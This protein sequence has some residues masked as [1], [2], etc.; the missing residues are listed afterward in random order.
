MA[1]GPVGRQWGMRE[2]TASM[3]EETETAVHASRTAG[4][5]PPQRTGLIV[6][7]V[8]A[9]LMAL[10]QALGTGAV[11]LPARLGYWLGI[12]ITGHF[13]GTGVTAA[14]WQ[15][16]RFED[17][18]WI[19][20]SIVA[21]AI[22]FPMTGVVLAASMIVFGISVPGGITLVNFYLIVLALTA[23]VTALSYALGRPA[24]AR[25][26]AAPSLPPAPAQPA[27]PRLADRLP[28]ALRDAPILALEAEDHYIRV[29]TPAGSELLLIRM[30]D[31]VAEMDGV[32]GARTHRSWWVRRSAV[33]AAE[34]ADGRAT[35]TLAGGLQVLVS[36]NG[37]RELQAA[38]WFGARGGRD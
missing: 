6:A 14:V 18:P 32:E 9:L 15:W 24:A 4:A 35:L 17:R 11:E 3:R 12:M 13:I 27:R 21:L 23:V 33:T 38:G 26:R 36:R 19:E 2:W 20:G 16:R 34:R 31:A 37:V 7:I 29:H 1:G 22:S 30:G 8:G 5:A 10:T 28:P 25:E